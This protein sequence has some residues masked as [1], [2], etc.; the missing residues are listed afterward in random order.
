MTLRKPLT[1]CVGAIAALSMLTGCSSSSGQYS[2]AEFCTV[3]DSLES[4]D[5]YDMVAWADA[6]QQL[7]DH[8]PDEFK[9]E[10]VFLSEAYH[11]LV[12]V[13][14]TDGQAVLDALEGISLNRFTSS[15]A[16]LPM[17]VD[18]VCNPQPTAD[19]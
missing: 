2:N 6:V 16:A 18:R 10:M 8:A 1:I 3:G 4:I 12:D 15:S 7:A 13:D 9:D 5:T 14:I 19:E 11:K 17:V